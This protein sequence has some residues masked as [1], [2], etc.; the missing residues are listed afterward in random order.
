[1]KKISILNKD[2]NSLVNIDCTIVQPKKNLNSVFHNLQ[3][4]ISD[5]RHYN[6]AILPVRVLV[7]T[8]R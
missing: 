7:C 8:V 6:I 3:N 5:N 1:M 2:M 4:E